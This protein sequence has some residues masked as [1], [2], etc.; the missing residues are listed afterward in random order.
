MVV[1]FPLYGQTV[2]LRVGPVTVAKYELK[3][4]ECEPLDYHRLL[5]AMA[6]NMYCFANPDQIRKRALPCEV[7]R[8]FSIPSQ[9]LYARPFVIRTYPDRQPDLLQIRVAMDAQAGKLLASHQAAIHEYRDDPA[10]RQLI[11]EGRF[12]MVTFFPTEAA[13]A[14]AKELFERARS[15]G[16]YFAN[17]ET[18]VYPDLLKITPQHKEKKQ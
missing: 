6:T 17:F 10:M 5:A 1:A 12:V 9:H 4:T 8:T 13:W 16:N 15:T 3:E 18:Y 11:D 7:E 2:Y 14:P